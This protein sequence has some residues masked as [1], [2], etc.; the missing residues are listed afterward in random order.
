MAR[1]VINNE[2]LE[3]LLNEEMDEILGCR[4]MDSG[5]VAIGE[6]AGAQIQ[7]VITKDED[8]FIGS[9]HGIV[10]VAKD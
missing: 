5:S 7:L 6:F 1:L 4:S 2:T 10:T 9:H 3:K 8:D